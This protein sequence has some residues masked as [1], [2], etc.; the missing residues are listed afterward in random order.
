[1][2][3]TFR[4]RFLGTVQVERDGQPVRGFRSRKALALLGYLARQDQPVPRE[5]LADLFWEDQTESRG[6]ANLSWVLNKIVTLLP[7]CMQA[8]RHTVQFQRMA[9]YWLDIDA[10]EQLE[11]RRDPDSLA[12]AV[13]LY[14]GEFLE[15]LYLARC[16]EFEIWLV[17]ERERWRQQVTGVLGELVTHHSQ[18]GEYKQGLRFAQRLLALEPWQEETH[19]QMMRLLAYNDQRGAAL[20]QYETCRRI[21][22]EELGVEPAAETTSLYEQIRTGQLEIPVLS[23]DRLSDLPAPRPSFLDKDNK[24]TAEKPVF[25]ARQ[26]ELT[27]LDGFLNAALAGQGQVVFVTGDAGQ[28]KTA[29]VQ[30]FARRAQAAHPDL[31]VAGGNGN[32]Y[33]GVG[34][35]YLPFREILSLLTGNVEA[36]W[37]AGAMTRDQALRLW[38]T[39]P[40]AVQAL[41]EIGPD[42]IDLFVPGAAL[43]KR[44]AAFT[45][46]PGGAAWL[47]RLKELVERKTLRQAQD[48]AASPGNPTLQQSAL[49]EQYTQTLGALASQKP[50]LLVLDDL[51]W[52]DGGSISLLFH[53]G[54]WLEGSRLLIVGAYR[55]T[56]VA[57]GH[58]ASSLLVGNS[59]PPLTGGI[60]VGRERHPLEPV[61]NEFKRHF[62]DVEVDLEQA[63]D[64]QFVDAIL[65]SEPNRLDDAFRR[66]LYEQ[67]RGHPLFT[68]EL[69]RGMQ[70]RRDLVQDE[71]GRWIEGAALD[72]KTLPVRV[73]AVIAER[74]GHLPERLQDA[75][76]LASVEGETFTAEVVARAGVVDEREIVR[77]LSG[78][79]DRRHRLVRAQGTR[80]MDGQRLSVYRFRHIL[81]QK[82]LYNN[83]DPVERA[84]LHET[85]GTVLETLYG[86]GAGE[87]AAVAPQLA[88]HFQEAGIAG[89][90]VDYL[91]QAGDQARRLYA[92]QE[93]IDYYQRAL[94]FLKEQGEYER[95][96]RTL[97]KMG[98]TYHNAFDFRQARQAYEESFALWQRAGELEPAVLPPTPHAL[99]QACPEPLALDPTVAYDMFSVPLI[100]QLFSGLAE[101]SPELNIVPGVARSWEVGAGGRQYVFHLRDDVRWSDGTPVTAEDFAFAWRRLLDPATRAAKA[102]LLYD[103]KGARAFHQ[104]QTSAPDCLGIQVL[105]PLTLVVELEQPA[106]YFLHLLACHTACPVP[107]HV[108]AKHGLAWTEVGKIVGNGPFRLETWKR[109]ESMVLVRNPAYYGRFRGNVQRVELCFLGP[110]G[111][112]PG[113]DVPRPATTRGRIRLG[114]GLVNF[115]PGLRRESPPL[116]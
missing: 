79:L 26:R 24:E 62:G 65:D 33:T 86:E 95:A 2:E 102:Q 32:A 77:W 3:E 5:H 67:T 56:E 114:T 36:R 51:Q 16:A 106:A 93:A 84:H 61:V 96:A 54:R 1:M 104:G 70:E 113:G 75:L 115:L 90:A 92:H 82:Y 18:R 40:L 100:S 37:A 11:T 42:L 55:P 105:D 85:V 9:P 76:T 111:L 73:E 60:E 109:G 28:G 81:F 64:R 99:R 108:A 14:R 112:H 41:V 74:I 69:L 57:L 52:A 30:E 48:T 71:T 103:I 91:C 89:K 4:L 38:H 13:E 83:L 22:A 21:L 10:F 8:D 87:I 25:V 50:L 49:F 107:R 15:G 101:L 39:L 66:M 72:W 34:D 45:P 78:E 7:G 35:P 116:R 29:L 47:S 43:V 31:V 27:Q 6:R 59:S 53:L 63:E 44:A 23:P 12:A 17:K 97:M 98:L 94:A 110:L 68:V 46:W 58:P 20:V 88:W 80:R 19:R